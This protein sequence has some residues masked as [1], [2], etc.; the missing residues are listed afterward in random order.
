MTNEE[1][2]EAARRLSRAGA[3]KGG[4]ARASVLTPEQRSE[5]ARRAVAAR[6]AKAG[7]APTEAKP[8]TDE[9]ESDR[10][11]T[12][13][14]S[15]Y[16]GRLALGSVEIE[17]HVLDDG[18]R[19]LA[20]REVVRLLSGGRDSGTLQ[21]YVDRHPTLPQDFIG[22]NTVQFEVPP[23]MMAATGFEGTALIELCDGYLEARERELLHPRQEKLAA[24]AEVIIRATAKVGIIALI[25]EATGY[26]EVR[27]KRALQIKLQAFI[28][29]DLQ[30]WAVR[31]PE[32]FFKE[33]ARLEGVHYSARHRPL[34][35]GR[36]VMMFVYDTIDEDVG[37]ELRKK[38]PNPRFL[39]NHHQWLKKHG[40]EKVQAQVAATIAIMKLCND[41]PDFRRKFARVFA[42]TRQLEL[43]DFDWLD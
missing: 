4:R 13:P 26:Q 34:R 3:S 28:A 38:N 11:T 39:S 43:D 15:A 6:W 20:Q 8:S 21:R 25:D 5:Q 41:M 37:R 29:E 35:W 14:R 16:R 24:A 9:P 32:E 1:R 40:V 19:V 18:R 22:A 27:H 10:S 30:E 7:K 17:C 31:F 42:K 12:L 23:N 33:L 2:S 36:Y